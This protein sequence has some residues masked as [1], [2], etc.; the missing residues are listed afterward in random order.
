MHAD[1]II[2]LDEGY[3]VGSGTHEE[4]LRSCPTYLEIAQSQLSADE[5]GLTDAE[6]AQIMKGGVC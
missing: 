6:I 5:L 4:L 2:V 3:V 1:K